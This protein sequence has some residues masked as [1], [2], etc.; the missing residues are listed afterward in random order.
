MVFNDFGGACAG[1]E[2]KMRYL[3]LLLP[4]F[5]LKIFLETTFWYFL[6]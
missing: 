4:L 2:I 6:S 1:N 3:L 5:L